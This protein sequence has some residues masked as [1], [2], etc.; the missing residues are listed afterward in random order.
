VLAVQLKSIT[1]LPQEEREAIAAYGAKTTWPAGFTVYERGTP[2]DG[3]FIVLRGQVVLRNQVGGGRSFVPWVATA[4]ETFGGEGLQTGSRYVST[5]RA[6]EESE[7]LQLSGPRFSALLREQP[8]H[9]LALIRQMMAERTALLEKFGE[10]AT[11][12]VEQ[13]LIA[14]LVRLAQSRVAAEDDGRPIPGG[15]TALAHGINGGVTIPRRLLGE[16]VGATRE[17]ISLV[18]GRLAGEGLVQRDG[19]GLVITDVQRLA[20][21]LTS[22]DQDLGLAIH[23]DDVAPISSRAAR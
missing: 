18:L 4:G 17:S 21:K 12:T 16:L 15:A 9:A 13:R 7:T 3:I 8:A 2:A 20:A 23:H 14:A 5:A 22:P 11:L 1:R 19:N 6:E 10:H